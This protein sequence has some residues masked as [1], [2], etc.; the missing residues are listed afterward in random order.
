M[1][2]DRPRSRYLSSVP[3]SSARFTPLVELPGRRLFG[4]AI[5][6]DAPAPRRL[7]AALT[8]AAAWPRPEPPTV[9]I[10]LSLDELALPAVVATLDELPDR[11]LRPDNVLVRV[12]AYAADDPAPLL[13][14]LVERGIGVAV[15]HLDLRGLELGLLAGA[16]VD[17]MELPDDCVAVAHRDLHAASWLRELTA[18]AHSHD[19]LTIASQVVDGE[20]LAALTAIGC[21]LVTGPAIGPALDR[22]GVARAIERYRPRLRA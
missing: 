16:P 12:P 15:R 19:W 10:D 14:R 1:T 22:T 5:G 3:E 17:V 18:R 13:E 11:G 7:E 6:V 4:F 9:L 20:Q 21:D 2:T 8:A